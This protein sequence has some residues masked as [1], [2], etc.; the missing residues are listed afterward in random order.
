MVV[1]SVWGTE[2]VVLPCR[3]SNF[4]LVYLKEKV[5]F[6]LFSQINRG[7]TAS[8]AR[9]WSN[10]VPQTDATTF[11]LSSNSI[12][13][14]WVNLHVSPVVL[15]SCWGVICIVLHTAMGSFIKKLVLHQEKGKYITTAIVLIFLDCI[16]GTVLIF[17]RIRIWPFLVIRN[18]LFLSLKGTVSRD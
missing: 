6:I 12:I 4:A 11:A 5:E 7:K 2:I 17:L 13:L 18:R 10:S 9:N 1:S 14:L 15:L 16:S 3:A 8:A